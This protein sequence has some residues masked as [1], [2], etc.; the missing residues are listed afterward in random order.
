MEFPALPT[1]LFRLI[2]NVLIIAVISVQYVTGFGVLVHLATFLYL[3]A[4]TASSLLD[5]FNVKGWGSVA[6]WILIADVLFALWIAP[7]G[8]FAFGGTAVIIGQTIWWLNGGQHN[9]VSPIDPDL[10]PVAPYDRDLDPTYSNEITNIFH[11][12]R[13]L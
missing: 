11:D 7:K 10:D 3:F 4:L 9:S 13:L 12:S 1:L 2:A 6:K 5:I 8:F